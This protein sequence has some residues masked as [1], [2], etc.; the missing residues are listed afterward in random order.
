[1]VGETAREYAQRFWDLMS[2]LTYRIHHTEH[3]EW[4]IGGR[5]PLIRIPLRQ[6]RITTPREALEQATRIESMVGYPGNNH[7][8]ASGAS[9]ELA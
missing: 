7:I 2:R 4:F 9:P 8:I 1:M 3:K 5:L 6:Q